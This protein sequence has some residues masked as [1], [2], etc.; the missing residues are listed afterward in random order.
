MRYAPELVSK[1]RAS[2]NIVDIIGNEVVLRKAGKDF[3]GLCPF[4][5]DR[6]PSFAVSEAKQVY[7]CYGCDKSGDVFTF[8]IE[9]FG[10]SFRDA[11]EELAERSKIKL[12]RAANE[13]PNED[14]EA[15]KRREAARE[16]V[17][18]AHKLNRFAAHFYHQQLAKFPAAR[19]YF[20]QR[21]INSEL[22]RQFYLGAAPNHW[23]TLSSH[24]LDKKAPVELAV[25]LGLIRPSQKRTGNVPYFDLFRNRAIF[26]ILDLRGKVVG[27]GGR[28]LPG[29][30]SG[31][32]GP[33]YLNSAGSLVYEKEKVL[34]GLAQA[35]KYIRE[36]DEAILVE[37][38]F[39]VIALHAAGIQNA[40][41]TCGTSLTS[42]HLTM[43]R[44]FASK[45]VVLFDGDKAGISATLRAMELGL[46][47]GEVLFGAAMPEG[48]D[49][50]EVIFDSEGKPTA[51]GKARMETILAEAKPLLDSR[52]DD[53]IASA[54]EGPEARTQALKKI[55]GWLARFRDPVGREVRVDS[56]IK[57]LGIGRDLLTRAMGGEPGPAPREATRPVVRPAGR[58]TDQAGQPDRPPQPAQFSGRPS[59][60]PPRFQPAPAP[61]AR[62]PARP[63]PRARPPARLPIGD[64]ILLDALIR[65]G[66]ASLLVAAG[67]NLPP[68][69]A[70]S[71]L[72]EA[73]PIREFVRGVLERPGALEGFR[74]SPEDFLDPGL[75]PQVRT[76]FTK[77]LLSEK[78]PY[79]PDE[80]KVA[81]GRATA[82]NWVQFSQGIEQALAE[83]EAK[84]D[85]GLA[86]KLREEFLDVRRKIEEFSRFV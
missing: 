19:D 82:R 62:A 75:D 77:A 16:K 5:G 36:K 17:A 85:E 73:P 55:A 59:S 15:A 64:Q 14:P 81:V 72:F 68:K 4:H 28:T 61:A 57:R 56:V 41:A 27:F 43:L 71:D 21:G 9:H 50:D 66:Q 47:H 70:I 25:E 33:K 31:D 74:S 10:I 7:H 46:E 45:V 65:G 80:L 3:M 35:A 52:I 30:T 84:K 6:S 63:G 32:P 58:P 51:D 38:Y 18:L 22:E 39:D 76:L 44:K 24:I 8:M 48:L 78:S 20:R 67:T 79:S 34:Y 37:G 86:S 54:A 83:A 49:P 69:S 12:P 53:E 26:P 40:V 42:H 13:D 60:S 1:V 2:V 29:E 23:D 11:I